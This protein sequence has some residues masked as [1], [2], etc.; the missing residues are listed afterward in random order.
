MGGT[1]RVAVGPQLEDL[2]AQYGGQLEVELLGGR[3]HLALEQSDE[4]FALLG[5]GRAVERRLGGLGGLR[6]RDTSCESS[7]A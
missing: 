5:I 4:R 3:L 6:V 7:A 2:I 1:D